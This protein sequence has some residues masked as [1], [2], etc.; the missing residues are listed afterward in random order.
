MLVGSLY[1]NFLTSDGTLP[2]IFLKVLLKLA[3]LLNPHTLDISKTVLSLFCKYSM[4]RRTLC[5]ARYSE[6]LI[7]G[8]FLKKVE[9]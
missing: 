4:A 2:I 5:L 8:L 7:L 9:K 3:M 6:G 1:F